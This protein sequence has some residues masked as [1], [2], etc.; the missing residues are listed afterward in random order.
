MSDTDNTGN[1]RQYITFMAN[2]QEFASN[3]MAIREIRGWTETTALPHVPYYVRGVIN[4]RGMVLPVVDLKAKLGLGMTETS[5]KNVIIVISDG[6]RTTGILVDA[7]SDI[8]T[9]ADGDIQPTSGVVGNGLEAYLDGI[10]IRDGRMVT[11][12]STASL[13]DTPDDLAA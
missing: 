2:G 7:V 1:A 3:I 12:L 13:T 11:I 8:I 4:L 10:A 9:L 6:V 5:A